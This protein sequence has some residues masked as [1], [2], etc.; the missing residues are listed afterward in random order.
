MVAP[1]GKPDLSVGVLWQTQPRG[2]L[3]K[4]TLARKSGSGVGVAVQT[5]M[6]LPCIIPHVI[7]TAVISNIGTTNRNAIL[8]LCIFTFIP[9]V[10]ILFDI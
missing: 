4:S 6:A 3:L 8:P 2:L 9:S 5:L 7:S 1:I 10:E